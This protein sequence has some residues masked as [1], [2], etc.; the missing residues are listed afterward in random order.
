MLRLV[1]RPDPTAAAVTLARAAADLA[2]GASCAGC[3]GEPGLL[4]RRCRAA[5]AGPPRRVAPDPPPPGLPPVHALAAYEGVVRAVLGA[6]KE[7]GR[8]GLAGPLGDALAQVVSSAVCR[9]GGRACRVVL[10]PVPS[11]P[12]SARRR[13]HD[14]LVRTARRAAVRLRRTYAPAGVVP[15]LTHRRA[16]VDQAGLDHLER[17]ANLAGALA[18]RPGA[19]ALLRDAVVV[20]VD[21][22]M[23]TGATLAEAARALAAAGA[24]PEAAAVVA[25]TRRRSSRPGCPMPR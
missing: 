15:A 25:A 21:D 16:V 19:G 13:G 2:L 7:G 20:V 11:R 12:G 9:V 1:P 6:H 18:L 24:A 14:P 3:S 5:L 17:Q 23:T 8:L 10:V 4:C 22:V